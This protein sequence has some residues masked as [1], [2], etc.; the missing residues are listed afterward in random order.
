MQ[1]KIEN[2]ENQLAELRSKITRDTFDQW[3]RS[4]STKA[5][6]LQLAIDAQDLKDNWSN[7]SYDEDEQ[8]R[9]Q[10]QTQYIGGLIELIREIGPPNA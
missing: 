2:L 10:G 9:A 5:L 4:K 3:L 6:I 7:G 8:L 1:D